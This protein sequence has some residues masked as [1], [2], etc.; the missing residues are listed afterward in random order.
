MLKLKVDC[1][2]TAGWID[3]RTANATLEV[4]GK[5]PDAKSS[6]H[7]RDAVDD[8]RSIERSCGRRDETLPGV[9]DHATGADAQGVFL[10]DL[11]LDASKPGVPAGRHS[12]DREN[13]F[14][15]QRYQRPAALRGI[16]HPAGY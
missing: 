15:R 16:F 2:F 12:W 13:L 5:N 6:S 7:D 9:A 1:T 10:G 14:G 4:R 11:G 3:K 8:Y